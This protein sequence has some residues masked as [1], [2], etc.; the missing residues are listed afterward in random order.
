MDGVDVV[1]SEVDLSDHPSDEDYTPPRVRCKSSG[2]LLPSGVARSV[3]KRRR[4]ANVPS[5]SV[6][7][8]CPVSLAWFES[9]VRQLRL[10]AVKILLKSA[11]V[12]RVG[13]GAVA[14]KLGQHQYEKI[15]HRKPSADDLSFHFHKKCRISH[16]WWSEVLSISKAADILKEYHPDVK[17]VL[18]CL[19]RIDF[20]YTLLRTH[21]RTHMF[22]SRPLTPPLTLVYSHTHTHTLTHTHTR[23]HPRT[24]THPFSVLH[25]RSLRSSLSSSHIS[26]VCRGR[27]Y[28]VTV[29][30]HF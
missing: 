21:T 24:P 18:S 2:P 25:S 29:L 12:V 15:D 17:V 20:E 28:Q 11:L 26:N 10:D 22:L 1:G 9:S 5:P 19:C 4:L 14:T 8:R 13:S 6:P 30:L 27:R 7:L 23:S 16:G 3:R